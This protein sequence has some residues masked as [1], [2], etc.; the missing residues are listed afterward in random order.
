M[1]SSED[2]IAFLATGTWTGK[3]LKSR[4]GRTDEEGG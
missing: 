3:V 2:V 1:L 4:A